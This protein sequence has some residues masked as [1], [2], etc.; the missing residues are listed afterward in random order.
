MPYSD[1]REFISRL[2]SSG[3]LIRIAEPVRADLEITAIADRMM[4]SPGGGK[5][6][7]FEKVTR[8][9]ETESCPI[10]VLVNAYGS[11][12]RVAWALGVEDIEEIP[13][14]IRELL[15]PEIPTG[16][17]EKV[18]MLPQLV[19]FTRYPPKLVKSGPCQEIAIDPPDITRLPV[20]KCWPKDGGPFFTLPQ[21]ITKGLEDGRRNVGMY[22]MQ[23]YD[24]ATTGMHWHIHH[25]GCGHFG[26]YRQAGKR[27]EIA[28]A[29][30]GDPALAYCASAPLPDG[31]DEYLFAGFIRRKPV[32]LVKC[33]T[34]DLEVPADA[35][36]ILEGY[37]DPAELRIEG[38][39]GDHTGFYSLQD[40]YPVFHVTAIMHRKDPVYPH[41]VVGPPPMEDYYL[42]WAT[43]RI[44]LPLIQLVL[45]EIVDYALPAE[46]IFHNFVFVKI[47]KRFPGHAYKVMNAI[48]GLGQLMF[49]KF[50]VVVDDWVDVHNTSEVLW[51]LGNHCE[52]E[53]D[54][55]TTK[56]PRDALDH[57]TPLAHYGSK[58]GF[59]ATKKW[60]EE[61][62]NRPWP[63][64]L[65]MDPQIVERNKNIF[66]AL[67]L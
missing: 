30:G 43:E 33:R 60:P 11:K 39:F 22:R 5:A 34:V 57:A 14:R 48:W 64:R 67:G 58:M 46:G 44:F 32:E 19:E 59:D 51:V 6:L 61:G 9:G 66:R 21:V 54:T 37:V 1:L 55:L 18:K 29:L 10:P 31:I 23:V 13:S 7:L 53:R 42:G 62:H 24:S 28:V 15:K 27:M 36:F 38:P 20:C 65:E 2:E 3:E 50:V 40:E 26:E 45:P 35:E 17:L 8:Q 12:K 25:G 52:P 41:T 49:S 16:F 56:G 4:K 63:E 47:R